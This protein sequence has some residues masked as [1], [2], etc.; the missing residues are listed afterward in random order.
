M[1]CMVLCRSHETIAC[2]LYLKD[3]SNY[4]AILS[5]VEIPTLIKC[6]I[7]LP[8]TGS[9]LEWVLRVPW[10]PLRFCEYQAPVLIIGL[11]IEHSIL[12]RFLSLLQEKTN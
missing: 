11:G 12:T 4:H 8:M 7:V 3:L 10:H 9:S 1:G 5:M 2:S 6:T